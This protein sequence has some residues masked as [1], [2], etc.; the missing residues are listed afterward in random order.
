MDTT[1]QEWQSEFEAVYRRAA[2]AYQ[3]G[4]TSPDTM[5]D[6]KDAAFLRSIGATRQEIFD[7]VEDASYGGDPSYEQVLAVTGIRR[8]FF[9][10]ELDGEFSEPLVTERSLP[11][12]SDMV[13]GVR[14]LPRIIAKG[15]A[16]LRGAL[17][18]ELMYGCGGDRPFLRE[19]GITLS[20]FLTVVRDA[21]DDDQAI[22]QFYLDRAGRR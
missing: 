20:E 12:K 21:G 7:Y 5:F 18:P 19:A 3:N 4:R 10:S 22:I 6:E 14:W 2:A 11:R 17:P 1:D 9:F 15:R 13:E 8:D 16:K